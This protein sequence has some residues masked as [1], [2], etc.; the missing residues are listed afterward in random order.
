MI[1]NR[2]YAFLHVC[3]QSKKH[4]GGTILTSLNP[5]AQSYEY[6]FGGVMRKKKKKPAGKMCGSRKNEMCSTRNSRE[7]EERAKPR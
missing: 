7:E 6:S 1:Q 4:M 2:V 5:N 3:S